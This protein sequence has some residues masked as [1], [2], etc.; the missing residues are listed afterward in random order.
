MTTI[1]LMRPRPS[2]ED[3]EAKAREMGFD[4]ISAPMLELRP[5]RCPEFERF[6][7]VHTMKVWD[8]VVFTSANGVSYAFDCADGKVELANLKKRLSQSQVVAIGPKTREALKRHGVRVR[9]VPESYSS[10]GMIEMFSKL[11]PHGKSVAIIRSNLGSKEIL[12]G[13][14]KMGARV[15]DLKIYEM[16]MPRD[17]SDAEKLVR[18]AADGDVDVF[19]FTSSMTVK[20]F[21]AVADSLSLREKILSQMERSKVAAIGKPTATTI[22]SEGAVADIVPKQETFEAMLAEIKKKAS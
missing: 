5:I 3:S 21:F 20:N 12:H 14:T 1:A 22:E 10:S 17:R 19:C 6:V 13:L 18:R 4:V 9:H 8:Y 2:L 15:F 11:H 7:S 16:A